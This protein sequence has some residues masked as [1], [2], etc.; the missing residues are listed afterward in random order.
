MGL[1]KMFHE[2]GKQEGKREGIILTLRK[3][4]SQRFGAIPDW[5]E[6]RLKDAKSKDLERWTGHILEAST[7]E[8]IFEG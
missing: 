6:D 7:L 8:E 3:Q 1:R 4:L 5:T 2:E